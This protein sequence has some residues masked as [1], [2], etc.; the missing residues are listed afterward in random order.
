MG[1]LADLAGIFKRDSAMLKLILEENR[2]LKDEYKHQAR[3]QREYAV[4]QRQMNEELMRKVDENTAITRLAM[5]RE[6]NC[7][8]MLAES[9]QQI[10]DLKEILIFASGIDPK[11]IEDYKLKL[12]KPKQ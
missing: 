12:K 9:Q 7:L 10:R 6:E 11:D 5:D 3:E 2:M 1:W 8:K 4:A